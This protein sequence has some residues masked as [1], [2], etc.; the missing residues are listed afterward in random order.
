M[1][2][3]LVIGGTGF[4]GSHLVEK[5]W[6]DGYKVTIL[7]RKNSDTKLSLNLNGVK[8]C[9]GDLFEQDSLDNA[10]LKIDTV[11]CLVNVKP[12][13]KTPEEYKRQLFLLHNKGTINLVEALKRNKVKRLIYLSSIAIIGYQEGINTYDES[14]IP[15]PVDAYGK[16]K[17]DA[18][19]ILNEYS[20]KGEIDIT[21]LRPVSVFGERGLGVLRKIVYL[22]ER[23]LVFVIGSGKNRQSIIYVGNLVNQ[24]LHAAKNHRSIG[25]TYIVSHQ[26]PYTVNDLIANVSKTMCRHPFV[27]HI[28]VTIIMIFIFLLNVLGN[29][30]IGREIVDKES[31]IAIATERVFD[32]SKFF[33][34]L[35]YK[36]KCDLSSSIA[37]TIKWYKEQKS[38]N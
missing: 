35:N 1:R 5:L 10:L 34:E 24:I 3:V 33:E 26:C 8:F 27:I 7:V 29:L 19:N 38:F 6:Q 30:F 13:G 2:N 31:I 14:V 9:Q 25:K 23:G 22:T 21:I 4:I 15:N 32:S 28:P 12:T 20:R 18:E 36:E 17:L 37:L 11:F 16:S